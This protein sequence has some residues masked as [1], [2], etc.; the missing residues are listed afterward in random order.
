MQRRWSADRIWA[1]ALALLS[2]AQAAK[3][4]HDLERLCYRCTD[5]QLRRLHACRVVMVVDV[6]VARAC[7]FACMRNRSTNSRF[8]A[9][10]SHY[11]AFAGGCGSPEA[12]FM[13]GTR[14]AHVGHDAINEICICTCDKCKL[15]PAGTATCI[16]GHIYSQ[17]HAINQHCSAAAPCRPRHLCTGA[18]D[19]KSNTRVHPA[20]IERSQGPADAAQRKQRTQVW[21]GRGGRAGIMPRTRIS[22]NSPGRQQTPARP[23]PLLQAVSG[24]CT[25]LFTAVD[26]GRGAPRPGTA[27]NDW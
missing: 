9:H 3:L 8:L 1:C 10:V 20:T 18:A 25:D 24:A 5:L 4:H 16:G 2:S 11:N 22:A 15:S 6:G 14:A 27:R 13:S 19:A 12:R 17:G 23:Q 21:N 26:N 7:K